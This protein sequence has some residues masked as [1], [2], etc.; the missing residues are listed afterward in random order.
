MRIEYYIDDQLF[1]SHG[2]EDMQDNRSQ[3]KSFKGYAEAREFA[4]LILVSNYMKIVNPL[5]ENMRKIKPAVYLVF[6]SKMNSWPE[7]EKY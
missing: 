6:E 1:H 4:A 7:D 5:I 2:F 3:Y